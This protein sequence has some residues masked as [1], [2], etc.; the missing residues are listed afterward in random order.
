MPLGQL[1]SGDYSEWNI[2][3]ETDANSFIAVR[4]CDFNLGHWQGEDWIENSHLQTGVME[5]KLL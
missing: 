4:Y 1:E 3:C 5:R 2:E